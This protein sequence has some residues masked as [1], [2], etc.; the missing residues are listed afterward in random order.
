MHF[1][2]YFFG[3]TGNELLLLLLLAVRT[4]GEER[5]EAGSAQSLDEEIMETTFSKF[6]LPV[7][8][9]F[10]GE[11]SAGRGKITLNSSLSNFT[12]GSIRPFA[13]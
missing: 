6:K 11:N 4:A 13:H 1:P 2:I 10:N 5:A 7:I 3:D 8:H 9:P 12:I